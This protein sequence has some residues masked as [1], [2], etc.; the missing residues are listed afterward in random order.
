MIDEMRKEMREIRALMQ[1]IRQQAHDEE[2]E[3]DAPHSSS[4]GRR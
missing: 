3:D 1:R 2:D 4:F